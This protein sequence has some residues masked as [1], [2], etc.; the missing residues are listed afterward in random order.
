MAA[1]VGAFAMSR[2]IRS[3]SDPRKLIDRIIEAAVEH[4][5]SASEYRTKG[6]SCLRRARKRATQKLRG[7]FVSWLRITSRLPLMT[8]TY[9]LPFGSSNR[10]R[11]SSK[12]KSNAT[13][14]A[15][16]P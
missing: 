8:G 11:V 12:A 14:L 9:N 10:F 4:A 5:M 3:Q 7:Y 1:I 2:V 13:D 6:E 16:E 15:D